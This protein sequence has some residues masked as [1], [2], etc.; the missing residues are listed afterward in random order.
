MKLVTRPFNR[1]LD[2]ISRKTN[3]IC[4]FFIRQES[5]VKK[6]HTTSKAEISQ[7]QPEIPLTGSMLIISNT[8]ALTGHRHRYIRTSTAAALQWIHLSPLSSSYNNIL[9]IRAPASEALTIR[10]TSVTKVYSPI[11]PYR[12]IIP[13]IP[14][15]SLALGRRYRRIRFRLCTKIRNLVI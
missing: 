3:L 7:W 10:I 1:A 4:N 12:I 14:E 15:D 2:Q 13:S 5:L 8:S 6:R 11:L 9:I